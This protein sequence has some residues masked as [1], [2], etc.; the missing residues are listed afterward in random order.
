MGRYRNERDALRH[1]ADQLEEELHDAESRLTE[2]EQRLAEQARK[3]EEEERQIAFLRSEVDRLRVKV[4]EAPLA[5]P[6]GRSQAPIMIAAGALVVGGVVV[7]MLSFSTTSSRSAVPQP[8]AKTEPAVAPVVP[9][10]PQMAVFGAE[11]VATTNETVAVGDGCVIAATLAGPRQVSKVDVRC[12]EELYRSDMEKGGG[13]Q[14]F[15]RGHTE[16]TAGEGI[17]RHALQ[18]VRRGSWTGPLPQIDLNSH[19]HRG[20]IWR[21][22][23]EPW[24]ITLHLDSFSFPRRGPSLGT[25][26][27]LSAV[28]DRRWSAKR[29]ATEGTPPRAWRE[30]P[31]AC[32]VALSPSSAGRS[33]DGTAIDCR[34]TVRCGA[35]IFYGEGD[36]GFVHCPLEGAS[37]GAVV[38]DGTTPENGDPKLRLEPA[39]ATVVVA[40]TIDG[41]SFSATFELAPSS[42]CLPEASWSGQVLTPSERQP[43]AMRVQDGVVELGPRGE[44]PL[45]VKLPAQCGGGALPLRADGAPLLVFGPGRRTLGGFTPAGKA[46]ALRSEGPNQVSPSSPPP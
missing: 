24:S 25:S 36:F 5:R 35:V 20:H 31:E 10:D 16:V 8:V 12:G 4:G 18:Y 44:D 29:V 3:D 7:G 13:I 19:Q 41:E 34:V 17:Y 39:T 38:D 1:R 42:D 30:A 27:T 43:Y 45:E 37:I 2:A 40:D 15:E 32:E 28:P 46:L 11:V 6:A 21:D 33:S 14:T 23:P 26:R 9:R 22:G